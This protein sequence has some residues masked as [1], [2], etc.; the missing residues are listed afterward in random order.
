MAERQPITSFLAIPVLCVG[1]CL[2]AVCVLVPQAEANKRLA[3]EREQLRL[4]VA[5]A[6]A[7]LAVNGRFLVGASADPEVAERL[8]QRQ[9]RRIRG[10]TAPLQLDGQPGSAAVATVTDML[11]VPAPAP[12]AAYQPPTGI[13]GDVAGST[14][15]QLYG[16]TA[17]LFLV[18]VSLVLGTSAEQS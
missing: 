10:G 14:R 1:L 4:D 11:R 8:A 9:M 16:L 15:R 6:D 5:H 3:V 17:G 18:G 12:V 2:I 13:V 7:Q